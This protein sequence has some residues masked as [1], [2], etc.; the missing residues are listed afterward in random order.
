MPDDEKPEEENV[1]EESPPEPALPEKPTDEPTPDDIMSVLAPFVE[2]EKDSTST[3]NNDNSEDN[4]RNA[5][6]EEHEDKEENMPKNQGVPAGSLLPPK[7]FFEWV[8]EHKGSKLTKKQ[9]E[10]LL[11]L[12][13]HPN[14]NLTQA[15][16]KGGFN[17]A[18]LDKVVRKAQDLYEAYRYK[19]EM[20]GSPSEPEPFEPSRSPARRSPVRAGGG[21]DEKITNAVL[22]MSK[23]TTT[24]KEVDKTIASLLG[25]EFHDAAVKK[26]IYARLG[27][28]L[29]YTLM[30]LGAIDRDKIV[31]YSQTLVE[32]PDELYIYVK[33]QLDAVIK[34]TDPDT[35]QQV[36]ME[37]AQLRMKV[38][39]LEAT[40]DMLSDA[41]NYYGDT[42]RALIGLLNKKQL[43]KFA[44]WIYMS[45]YMRKMKKK[46][47]G[48][49][50][51]GRAG[52]AAGRV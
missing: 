22:A 3:E 24:F 30:Q 23:A 32:N 5:E 4:S 25:V 16:V 50:D 11:Y 2:D 38:M 52:S 45:E 15:A 39:A 49:V 6:D 37:N 13:E 46:R 1:S 26:N 47:M 27:E 14:M 41:L 29:I 51:V 18:Y 8:L 17:R 7:A 35:L 12:Y 43:E 42:I 20:D 36:W 19:F 21:G 44:T 31:E 34:I 9:K 48:G 33:E 10:A 28:L 40:A